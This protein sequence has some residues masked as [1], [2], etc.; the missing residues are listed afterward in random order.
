MEQMWVK[1]KKTIEK[2]KEIDYNNSA[3]VL[4]IKMGV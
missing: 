4:K 2:T 3:L 1:F